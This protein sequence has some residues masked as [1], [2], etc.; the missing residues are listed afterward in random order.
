MCPRNG[1]SPAIS[2]NKECHS[3]HRW[4]AGEPRGSSGCENARY[5]PQR[6]EVRYQRNDFTEPRL[7]PLPIY[8]CIT[9]LL[10]LPPRNSSLRATWDAVS[11][12]WSLE[13]S[14]QIKRNP[15]FLGCMYFFSLHAHLL[16]MLEG[17]CGP[18]IHSPLL[19]QDNGKVVNPWEKSSFRDQIRGW[20]F[21]T[22]INPRKFCDSQQCNPRQGGAPGP[23]R[24]P[25]GLPKKKERLSPAVHLCLLETLFLQ[26]KLHLH[27]RE[28]ESGP[29]REFWLLG[30]ERSEKFFFG[31][32]NV[33]LRLSISL[34]SP[35]PHPTPQPWGFWP[36]AHTKIYFTSWH[37]WDNP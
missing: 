18:L 11:L 12:A 13:T 10:P 5:W 20:T 28:E 19:F 29:F 31:L 8:F 3:H 30:L 36:F 34:S 16:P 33:S 7:L 27:N 37:C 6:A 15:Q 24:K 9:W 35:K 26:P 2:V 25:V 1:T 22:A 23:R 21:K 4:W 14:F 32:Q 17:G